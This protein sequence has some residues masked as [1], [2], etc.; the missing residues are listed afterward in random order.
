MAVAFH[1]TQITRKTLVVMEVTADEVVG[2]ALGMA[3]IK[4]PKACN[5]NF[6]S[7]LHLQRHSTDSLNTC[8]RMG[9]TTCINKIN[10]IITDD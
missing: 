5:N 4:T 10:Q 6:R 2:K 3:K 8:P 9:T 1:K 7:Q